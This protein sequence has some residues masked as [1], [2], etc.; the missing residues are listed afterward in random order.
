MTQPAYAAPCVP[1]GHVVV[2]IVN[3]PPVAVTETIAVAVLEPEAFVAVS[4]YVVVVAGTTLVDPLADDDV[5]PP[6]EI[7]MLLAP[8]VTQLKTLLAPAVTLV[9]S[10]E[11]EVITGLFAAPTVTVAFEV[12]EPTALV[13]VSV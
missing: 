8:V 3:A 11:N 12:T 4:V 13:A 9:G 10:A 1:A 7:E 6:G 2:A 5:K